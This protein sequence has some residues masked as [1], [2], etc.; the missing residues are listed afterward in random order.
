M[1][2]SCNVISVTARK[3]G[4]RCNL[5][6]RFSLGCSMSDRLAE[7]TQRL[8]Q[9]LRQIMKETDP[10]KYDELGAEIWRVL[11]EKERLEQS[12]EGR[13]GQ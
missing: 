11:Q 6:Q 4:L 9:L 1:V 2:L 10:A 12:T 13:E 3:P 5:P 8:E 7:L